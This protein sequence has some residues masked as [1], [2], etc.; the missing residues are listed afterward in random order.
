MVRAEIACLSDDEPTTELASHVKSEVKTEVKT[1][2]KPQSCIKSEV[3][4]ES[5][6][7]PSFDAAGVHQQIA[8]LVLRACRCKGFRR[9]GRGGDCLRQFAGLTK[10]IFA[11]RKRLASLHK[12]DADTEAWFW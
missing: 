11:I 6:G 7:N 12:Q 3:K 9:A 5:E 4:T 1:E 10:E 2:V 8:K